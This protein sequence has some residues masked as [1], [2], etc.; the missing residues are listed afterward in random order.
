MNDPSHSIDES[1]RAILFVSLAM[2]QTLFFETL[3]KAM[4]QQGYHVAHLCFHERSFEYLRD[5]GLKAYNG[6]DKKFLQYANEVRLE[7]YEVANVNLLLNHEKA[8]FEIS[9]TASLLT[10]L[11]A[12][13]AAAREAID[14]WGR[15][16]AK[17]M[18]VVQELG[19]FLSNIATFYAARYQNIDNI[20][21]EPSFYRERVFFVTNSFAAPEISGAVEEGASIVVREYLDRIVAKRQIVIPSKDSHNYR[22][23]WRKLFD[24]R[25][26]R[27]LFE[28]LI[29][30]HVLRKQEQFE[31]IGG[32]VR[33]YLRMFVNAR[34]LRRLSLDIPERESFIYYPLHV[35]ADVALTIRSPEYLD[36]YALIDFLARSIP[37]GVKLAIKEHPAMVGAV[38]FGRLRDVMRKR[39]NILLLRADANNH[40]I[41]Q[42]AK[43]VVTVN[44]KAGAEALVAGKP[45]VVLGDAFYSGAPGAW[46]VSALKDLP[47]VLNHIATQG[48][49]VSRE[50]VQRY[51]E[52]VWGQS[53][54]GELYDCAPPNVT[55]FSESLISYLRRSFR[56]RKSGLPNDPMLSGRQVRERGAP[57]V[58]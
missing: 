15:K 52:S 23:P 14:D 39:D 41:V 5:N 42:R 58:R 11:R 22:A 31:H 29:D 30:K 1:T 27:R 26:W 32:H 6:F 18:V 50:E 35:P 51:F 10:R 4:E 12:N 47:D 53:Y 36:Q 34:R 19:G 37:V 38:D 3:G 49:M 21:I 20:F 16:Q 13:L 28:K 17:E 46:R 40:E 2:N 7:D 45:V 55:Q 48:P 44:S 56:D 25:N 54:R 43:A 9:D 8:A 57:N 24:S 33:R